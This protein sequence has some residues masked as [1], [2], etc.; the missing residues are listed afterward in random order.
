MPI[1]KDIEFIFLEP[2]VKY[3]V[4]YTMYNVTFEKNKNNNSD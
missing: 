2:H 4:E 3:D 1:V